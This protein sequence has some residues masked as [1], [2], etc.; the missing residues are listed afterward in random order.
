METTLEQRLAVARD[1]CRIL[2]HTFDSWR[3]L[4]TLAPQGIMCLHCGSHWRVHPDDA[5]LDF[6]R[7]SHADPISRNP[8]GD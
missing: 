7:M 8:H 5:H 6:G 2:G 1:E 3:T 4:D